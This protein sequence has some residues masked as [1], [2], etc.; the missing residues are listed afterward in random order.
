MSIS[1]AEADCIIEAVLKA[2]AGK[3]PVTVVV[4][5]AGGAPK[6]FK[7]QDGAYLLDFEIALGRAFASLSLSPGTS[8]QL[9]AFRDRNPAFRVLVD[10][11][12]RASQG[13]MVVEAGG[14]RVSDAGQSVIGAVGVAGLTPAECQALAIEG[15]KSAGFRAP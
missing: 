8:E 10:G 4:T 14:V 3:G 7:K 9:A 15:A 2:A 5:D 1:L 6:A 13:R 11:V 12:I